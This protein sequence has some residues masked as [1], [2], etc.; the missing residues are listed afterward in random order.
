MSRKLTEGKVVRVKGR[1]ERVPLAGN[2]VRT[3]LGILRRIMAR[4][5]RAKLVAA[6]PVDALQAEE[7][8]KV[9]TLG[10]PELELTDSPSSWSPSL[11]GGG[12]SCT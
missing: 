6:N 8:P 7:R 9:E 12:R 2:T 3:V 5:V 4:A 10:Y 11:S 1:D